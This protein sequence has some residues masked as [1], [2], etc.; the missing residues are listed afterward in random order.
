MGQI[1]AIMGCCHDKSPFDIPVYKPPY[2]I[3]PF[4]LFFTFPKRIQS[5]D[6]QE[7]TK[8]S[9][10]NQYIAHHFFQPKNGCKMRNTKE[11]KSYADIDGHKLFAFSIG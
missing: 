5:K 7:I 10:D 4:F 1:K 2:S 8:C 6:N 11:C 3:P 9:N